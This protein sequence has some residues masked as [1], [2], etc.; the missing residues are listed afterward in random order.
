MAPL[1]IRQSHSLVPSP[2]RPHKGEYTK[3]VEVNTHIDP[4]VFAKLFA[5]TVGIFILSVLIWKLGNFIRSFSQYRVLREGNS[6]TTRYAKTWYGWVTLKTH[7]RNKQFFRDI[8]TKVSKWTAW[9]ST[10]T[11]YRWV[12]WD[13]G[14]A[15][16]TARRRNR[17]L[18]RWLPKFLM[19][20]ESPTADEIWN[21]GLRVE[22]HGALLV[23]EE[24]SPIQL[25]ERIRER[26]EENADPMP[27]KPCRTPSKEEVAIIMKPQ[28]VYGQGHSRLSIYTSEDRREDVVWYDARMHVLSSTISLE[29]DRG[30]LEKGKSPTKRD[31]LSRLRSNVEKETMHLAQFDGPGSFR[32]TRPHAAKSHQPSRDPPRGPTI[33]RAHVRKYQVWSAKMQ[34]QAS[35]ALVKDLR[36]SSGPP[37]TP[38]VEMFAS[39]DSE[40]SAAA[41]TQEQQMS[42]VSE[43]SGSSVEKFPFTIQQAVMRNRAHLLDR[44]HP[45]KTQ[46]HYNTLPLRLNGMTRD[47]Q[48][49]GKMES[50]ARDRNLDITRHTVHEVR[51]QD[52]VKPGPQDH[53]IVPGPG[54][55]QSRMNL[56]QLNDWEVRLIDMVDRKLTWLVNETTPGQK[57]YHFS[58]LANHWLNRETWLVIDP[59]SRVSTD[60]RR[61]QGDPRHNVPYPEPDLGRRPKYPAPV[62]KRAHHPRIDSWRAAVNRQRRVSGIRERIQ[63]VELYED[64]A[65]EP[66][67]GHIDPA[68][69]MLPRPPQGFEMSSKQRNAWYEGGAGWQ[70]KLDDWKAVKRGYR[71]RRGIFDGR[72]N[73]NRVIEIGQNINGYCRRVL[74]KSTPKSA[75]RR[76]RVQSAP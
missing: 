65:E 23:P 40:K 42:R 48:G 55:D 34:V 70:E 16:L 53:R 47:S 76:S 66:P 71:L 19:S 61:N 63:P 5:G 54:I 51:A 69:W 17:R 32:M 27:R 59:V 67:D 41:N 6:P 50:S 37:G 46:T 4:V 12:W 15:A 24:P 21:P 38:I 9:K 7:E 13:P 60:A 2:P 58:L 49:S 11:D 39:L 45:G 20:Y 29:N 43:R 73:R 33:P 36:D 1:V 8:F 10:R 72:V 64:S 56:N 3:P 57:P 74:L 52:N 28:D 44:A 30:S 68:C 25:F 35:K 26:S 22:C 62:R 18:L 31:A 75:E 14:Q